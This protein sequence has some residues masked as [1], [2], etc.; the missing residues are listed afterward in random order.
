[1]SRRRGITIGLERNTQCT[2]I[3]RRPAVVISYH[4]VASVV[5]AGKPVRCLP[6]T[7]PPSSL[8]THTD[9]SKTDDQEH[10]PY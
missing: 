2:N 1:M 7:T 9:Y 3:R 10:H 5:R 6:Q 4:T 8:H